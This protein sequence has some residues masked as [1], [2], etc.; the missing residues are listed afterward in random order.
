M[1]LLATFCCWC[2]QLFVVGDCWLGVLLLSSTFRFRSRLPGAAGVHEPVNN[3]ETRVQLRSFQSWWWWWGWWWGGGGGGRWGWSIIMINSVCLSRPS[4]YKK[5]FR[6]TFAQF[7]H[8]FTHIFIMKFSG[9]S[10]S[11]N[12]SVHSLPWNYNYFPYFQNACLFACIFCSK[13]PIFRPPREIDC[14]SEELDPLD[15]DVDNDGES[16]VKTEIPL[17]HTSSTVVKSMRGAVK[18]LAKRKSSRPMS[19]LSVQ[20]SNMDHFSGGG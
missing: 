5:L 7:D 19:R 12:K 14:Q 11:S 15:C 6:Q 3:T 16:R 8:D 10:T 1:L 2:W 13:S 9:S 20:L 4:K 18:T 17:S